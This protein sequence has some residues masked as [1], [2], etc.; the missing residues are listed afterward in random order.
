MAGDVV[1]PSEEKAWPYSVARGGVES[2]PNKAK[3]GTPK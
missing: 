1:G 2:R 3:S